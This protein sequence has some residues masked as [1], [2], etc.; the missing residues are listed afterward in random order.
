MMK[1]A[2]KIFLM[3]VFIVATYNVVSK[4][5]ISATSKTVNSGENVSIL[6]TSNIQLSAYTVKATGYNGL[7]FV[8]SSGGSGAGTTSI[9]DAKAVGGMTSLATFQFRAPTVEKDQ[10]FQVSF[11]ATGMGDVNL[12]GV[13]DSSCT[14]TITVKAKN[15]S[16]DS[17]G[18]DN[19]NNTG[20]NTSTKKS[21]VATLS[22]LGIRPNDFSGF[23]AN[24]LN[25]NT[26]V[27]NETESIEIYASKGHNGQTISG[28]GKKS[29]KEGKNTFNIVVTAEDGKTQKTYTI[30]VTRKTKEDKTEETS[31]GNTEER[32]EENTETDPLEEKFGLS[33]LKIEGLEIEPQFQTDIYEYKVEL[34]EDLDKL[35]ITTLA[36]KANATVE[37]TGN[38]NLKE[39]ENII[40]ILVKGENEDETAAYQIV[41]N[42]ILE[43][44]ENTENNS[45][46]DKIKKIIIV[47]IAGG[48]I[49]V[50]VVV[51]I[52]TKIK[53]SKGK[54]NGYI[55]YENLMDD[56]E[57]S[58]EG[59][60]IEE[61]QEDEEFYQEEPKKKKRSKGKRF[62]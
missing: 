53:K 28:T 3:F 15:Q 62:K 23:K 33:E 59:D 10:T 19:E 20:S 22:N 5:A 44:Q 29:L 52:V 48:I 61:N 6:V 18:N 24:T 45:N 16:T 14:A 2:I 37:I 25:Y 39:G 49:L 36:T 4:A 31:N 57:E 56:D 13:P 50:I 32:P 7:T 11:S 55:P 34:K 21:N 35:N 58:D 47:S 26:E 40:T 38:E 42:K 1:K 60:E 8:T 17:T 9:S 30:N 46:Q 12:A 51:A 27:P 43:K 54:G 41:V